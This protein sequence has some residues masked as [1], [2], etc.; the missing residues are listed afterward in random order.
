[1]ELT[2]FLA[3]SKKKKKKECCCLVLTQLRHK[4]LLDIHKFFNKSNLIES[5]VRITGKKK[6]V[7]TLSCTCEV[8]AE[9]RLFK[10]EEERQL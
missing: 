1:M 7:R 5:Q 10:W 2:I 6:D 4:N 3:R 9:L 8:E